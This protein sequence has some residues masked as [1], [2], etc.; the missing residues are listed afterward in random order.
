MA[1]GVERGGV[2]PFLLSSAILRPDRQRYMKRSCDFGNGRWSLAQL[3]WS[4]SRFGA[5]L[6]C[7]SEQGRDSS[8]RGPSLILSLLKNTNLYI[9]LDNTRM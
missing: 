2:C 7:G 5:A 1:A 8:V 9:F 6:K 4:I 3:L